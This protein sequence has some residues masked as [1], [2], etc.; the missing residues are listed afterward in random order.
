M[1]LQRFV[2]GWCASVK[3][4]KYVEKCELHVLGG[5]TMTDML[6][7]ESWGEAARVLAMYAQQSVRD[8]ALIR[9]SKATR[10][11]SMPK[12]TISRLG[13]YLIVESIGKKTLVDSWV[14]EPGSSWS[15][16]PSTH[17]LAEDDSLTGS[18][19]D[20]DHE[21]DHD[22]LAPGSVTSRRRALELPRV[23]SVQT[24]KAQ[25][26]SLRRNCLIDCLACQG[27]LAGRAP[28][29]NASVQP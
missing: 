4:G 14:P 13:Y 21:T 1:V 23:F 27:S 26:V 18:D 15:Q 6:Y 16:I 5:K 8:N 25:R 9:V 22:S 29:H 19:P 17:P 3:G 2:T 7:I 12:K 11:E 20:T 28:V 10:V 24:P